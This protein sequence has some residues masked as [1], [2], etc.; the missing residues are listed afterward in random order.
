MEY[1]V[2]SGFLRNLKAF[3]DDITVHLQRGWVLHGTMTAV[4]C[5]PGGQVV[6]LQTVVRDRGV[7]EWEELFD[8]T[9]QKKWYRNKRTGESTYQRPASVF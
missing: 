6:L 9:V 4:P 5:S 7:H 8:K 2:C 3:N 1:L